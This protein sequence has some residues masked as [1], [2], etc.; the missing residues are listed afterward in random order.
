MSRLF[1]GVNDYLENS[2]AVLSTVPIT[3]ACWFYSTSNSAKQRL[4]SIGDKDSTADFFHLSAMGNIAGDPLRASA[5]RGGTTGTASTSSG[6]SINTWHHATA[7]FTSNSNRD[8]YL[9]GGSSGNNTTSSTPASLDRTRIGLRASSGTDGPMVGRIA[10]AAIWSVALVA[11]EIAA[12]A[13]G[14]S[15]LFIRP[16][17]L[18]AYWPLGGPLSSNDADN[19]IAGAYHMTSSGSPSTADN[20]PIIYPSSPIYDIFKFVAPAPPVTASGDASEYRKTSDETGTFSRPDDTSGTFRRY[21]D[22][23]GTFSRP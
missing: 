10:E 11:G 18:K 6:Y 12:L 17:A 5:R 19:D 9:D 15:P 22:T 3:M 13:A 14:F 1:D 21:A 7:A 20:P 2:N 8:V 16:D 4:M 23:A